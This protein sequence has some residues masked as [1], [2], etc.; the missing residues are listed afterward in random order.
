VGKDMFFEICFR[1]E[2]Y[3]QIGVYTFHKNLRGIFNEYQYVKGLQMAK[4]VNP[5]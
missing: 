5:S 2:G 4:S 1:S 3:M